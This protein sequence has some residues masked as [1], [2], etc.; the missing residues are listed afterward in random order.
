MEPPISTASVHTDPVTTAGSRP[1]GDAMKWYQRPGPSA[2]LTGLLGLSMLAGC[3]EA[4]D[5]TGGQV[6]VLKLAS[7]DEVN[8]N[9]QS[10][11]PHAFVDNIGK[12]SG[13]R[14]KVEVKTDYGSGEA[15]AE[16]D[17]I[18]AIAAGEIDGGWPSTRAFATAGIDG[19]K[20]IEAPMTITNYDAQK[21]L[22][23]GPVAK[24]VLAQL[25][26]TGL[27]GLGLAVGPL[28][29]PFAATGPLLAPADWKGVRFRTY[30]SPVQAD[31]MA[32]LGATPVNVG[33]AWIDEVRQGTLRGAEFDIAQYA[34]NG[35]S[36]LAGNITGNIVLWPKVFVLSLSKK[37][38]DALSE[39]Q[40]GWVREAAARAV[41]ASAS[42]TYDETGVAKQLC[43]KGVKFIDAS[44]DQITAMRTS[45]KP[46]VDRL[47]DDPK[48]GPILQAIQTIAAAHPTSEAPNVPIACRQG[49][50]LGP[51][52]GQ[53]PPT[54][55]ALPDGVYRVEH[56][57][58][59]VTA[60]GLDN[61][62]G[63]SGTWTLTVRNGTYEIRCR[64]LSDP[65]R[66]C[67]HTVSAEPLDVGEL[68]GT[69]EIVYFVPNLERLAKVSGCKLPP[70]QTNPAHCPPIEAYRLT[71]SFHDGTLRF[72][73]ASREGG[74]E[75][76][77]ESLRKIG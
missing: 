27:V 11:G 38:F 35:E 30:N 10:F 41:A 65:G 61:H 6:L 14:L 67:G 3:G 44:P 15:Q 71:W 32:A 21:A 55:S 54:V 45:L 60:A 29:R 68:R 19:L 36:T 5:K 56:T 72:S 26:R 76:V 70:S 1:E 23:T 37:R 63:E 53:I 33:F 52:L 7:I 2:V 50:S 49:R 18:R 16:T 48:N 77:I 43:G 28:R 12:V 34:H 74:R 51:E 25:D 57:V 9:G 20:A 62:D 31:A 75:L 17:L 4:T 40:R 59:D 8:G 47:A 22:V 46:V 39:Q 24:T 13:G 73:A 66:D 69:G 42:A 58:A 64:P